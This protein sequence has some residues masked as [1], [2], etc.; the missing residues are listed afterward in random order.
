[1]SLPTEIKELVLEYVGAFR[2]FNEKLTL[3]FESDI[4]FSHNTLKVKVASGLWFCSTSPS[5]PILEYNRSALIL[6]RYDI[7]LTSL[8]PISLDFWMK[9]K[10]HLTNSI[11]LHSKSVLEKNGISLD[12]ASDDI[13]CNFTQIPIDELKRFIVIP[14]SVYS[15]KASYFV[16]RLSAYI[17]GNILRLIEEHKASDLQ[18][19]EGD[20]LK[21]TTNDLSDFFPDLLDNS[22]SS[23]EYDIYIKNDKIL[24]KNIAGDE[25][26]TNATKGTALLQTL[27]PYM[28]LIT[29]IKESNIDAHRWIF[30]LQQKIMN[31]P[32]IISGKDYR[33][34]SETQYKYFP[35]SKRS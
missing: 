27:Y 23:Y 2:V 11:C 30:H 26:E 29:D 24:I 10:H 3:T 34:I 13:R 6:H 16:D 32:L 4:P 8:P 12:F 18:G 1:M 31:D 25:I 9:G 22:N 15:D 33:I 21:F 19:P 28:K 7:D 35:L 17:C 20:E 14:I 5:V